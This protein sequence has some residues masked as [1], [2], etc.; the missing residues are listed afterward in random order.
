MVVMT[1][2]HN[3]FLANVVDADDPI[4]EKSCKKG[5]DNSPCSKHSC[6]TL[7]GGVKLYG[8][9]RRSMQN[10]SRS[11]TVGSGRETSTVAYHL[12]NLNWWWQSYDTRS[13]PF[14]G[15]GD[16]CHRATAS[17]SYAL[18]WSISIEMNPYGWHS[19]TARRSYGNPPA[20]RR[21]A[22]NLLRDSST[23]LG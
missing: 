15:V 1:G 13:S 22:A 9:M 6:S 4:S 14:L 23:L 16:S 17:S 12:G 20:S 19:Q 2:I 11:Y 21:A 7:T 3:V 10:S 8:W 5:R 18:Q